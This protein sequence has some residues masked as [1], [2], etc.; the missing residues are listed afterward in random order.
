MI[1]SV[2][3]QAPELYPHPLLKR[4]LPYTSVLTHDILVLSAG[5][6]DTLKKTQ[7][8]IVF[9]KITKY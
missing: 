8:S 2:M 5:M 7:G 9:V 4:L 6:E 3:Q 1:H